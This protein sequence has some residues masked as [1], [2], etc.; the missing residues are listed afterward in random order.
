MSGIQFPEMRQELIENLRSL[1]DVDYQDRMWINGGSEGRIQHD[2]FD[3]VVHFLYDDTSLA[4]DPVSLIGVI[5]R[6]ANEVA[7]IELVIATLENL[8]EKM[9]LDKT[10][11]EYV[12]S[13][14]WS[15]VVN[16]AKI[17]YVQLSTDV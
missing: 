4:D 1:S 14:W 11:E 3:Y 13:Q 2:E 9:G 5:L 7:L 12:R 17:A 6:N 10:D 8:F 16:A 15:D